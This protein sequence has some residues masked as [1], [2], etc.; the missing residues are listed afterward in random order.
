[1]QISEHSQL[2]LEDAATTISPTV[3]VTQDYGHGEGKPRDPA[4]QPQI[5]ISEITNK[6][7]GIGLEMLQQLFIRGAPGA[8]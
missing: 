5:P 7:N 8:V 4:G 1:M 3:M 6:E 2:L